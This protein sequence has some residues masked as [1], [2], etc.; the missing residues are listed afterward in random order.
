[1]RA[2]VDVRG[3]MTQSRTRRFEF[4]DVPVLNNLFKQAVRVL[5]ATMGASPDTSSGEGCVIASKRVICA[6]DA[7]VEHESEWDAASWE[8]AYF[9]LRELQKS[10]GQPSMSM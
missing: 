3:T 9:S 7:A 6:G 5:S 1:M 2:R 4:Y 10:G 8:L